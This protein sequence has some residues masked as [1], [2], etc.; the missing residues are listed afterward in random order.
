M[1]K[2]KTKKSVSKRF[3]VTKSGKVKRTNTKA[4]HLMTGKTRKHK[5]IFGDSS[6]CGTTDARNV[7][8]MLPY[9]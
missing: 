2:V 4:R 6:I 1:P 5:R 7:K 8:E 3:S 9:G